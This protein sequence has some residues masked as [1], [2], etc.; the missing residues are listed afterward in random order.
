MKKTR[1]TPV[2]ISLLLLGA[3][4]VATVRFVY[5]SDSTNQPAASTS[6]NV[7][8]FNVLQAHSV[9]HQERM[10]FTQKATLIYYMESSGGLQRVSEK[11]LTLSSDGSLVRLDKTTVDTNQSYLF[12][13]QTLVRTTYRS[14]TQKE[15]KVVDAAEADSIKVQIGTFG[16]TPLLKR[17]SEPNRQVV[18]LGASSKGNR[19]QVKATNGFLYFYTKPNHLIERLEF[20]DMS[21]TYGDYR[22]VDGPNLPFHQQVRKGDRLLYE[23]RFDTFDFNPVFAAH[24]FKSDL[25]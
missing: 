24:F 11:T 23:I 9:R 17:L 22:T 1:L 21:I 16:L 10:S 19:F 6:A 7:S 15:V 18:F 5:H 2:V 25:L 13:G 4:V 20:D 8:V 3:G 14:G 12:L